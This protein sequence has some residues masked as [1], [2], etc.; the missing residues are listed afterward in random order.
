M[1]PT[2][3]PSGYNSRNKMIWSQVTAALRIRCGD[4]Y[5]FRSQPVTWMEPWVTKDL[6]RPRTVGLPD[7]LHRPT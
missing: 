1:Q 7:V 3:T 5:Q 6:A 4:A 2:G